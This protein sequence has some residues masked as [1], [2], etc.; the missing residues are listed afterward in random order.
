MNIVADKFNTPTTNATHT[1]YI[2]GESFLIHHLSRRLYKFLDWK[3]A[4][5][6]LIKII[7]NKLS[8]SHDLDTAYIVFKMANPMRKSRL[9]NFY[10][11]ITAEFMYNGSSLGNETELGLKQ[12][13]VDSYECEDEEELELRRNV[14]AK[15]S[16]VQYTNELELRVKSLKDMNRFSENPIAESE[17]GF[18]SMAKEMMKNEGWSLTQDN[19]IHARQKRVSKVA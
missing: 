13:F 14:E 18:R 2:E 15:H 12:I 1:L 16:G 4:R 6:K 5:E 8:V 11:D 17:G 19:R 7:L 9:G 3:D 10:V